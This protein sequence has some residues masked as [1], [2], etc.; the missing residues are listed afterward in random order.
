MKSNHSA[1]LYH[2]FL[3]GVLVCF[4]TA[5]APQSTFAQ[6]SLGSMERLTPEFDQ[7]IA[8]DSKI[9]VLASGFTWTEDPVWMGGRD[10]F[11]LFSDIP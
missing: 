2:V 5:P 9:E 11:L 10:G 4:L 6:T 8:A 1:L 7:L 3:S